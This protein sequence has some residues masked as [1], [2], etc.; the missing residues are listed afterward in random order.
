MKR[1]L[2]VL[3]TLLSVSAYAGAPTPFGHAQTTDTVTVTTQYT[4]TLWQLLDSFVTIRSDSC[5]VI[6]TVSGVAELDFADRLYVGW[7]RGGGG[8][9][10]P[11]DTT[12][13]PVFRYSGMSRINY[14]FQSRFTSTQADT[15]NATDTV[16]LWAAIGGS[17][18]A[19]RV[20]LKKVVATSQVVYRNAAGAF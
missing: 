10:L 13:F 17:T 15:T 8:N 12:I 20:R 6:Y 18:T 11:T 4:D 1:F 14:D 9:D 19:E 7:R 3:L 16:Y 5:Y 2:F